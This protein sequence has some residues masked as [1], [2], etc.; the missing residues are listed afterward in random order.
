MKLKSAIFFNVS[1][2]LFSLASL[3]VAIANNDPNNSS[4]SVFT[5]FYVSFFFTCWPVI[6]LVIFFL[7]SRFSSNPAQI[8][9][10]L[11]VIRQSLFLAIGLTILLMLKGLKIFDWWVGSSI[12][13]SLIL[14]ELFF[15][16]KRHNKTSKL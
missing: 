15:E 6:A 16:T 10:Y 12:I 11:P 3:L 4:V 7:K 5:M 13:I 14:L 8:S 2:L 9:T 1:I